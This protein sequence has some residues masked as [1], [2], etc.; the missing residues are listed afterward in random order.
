MKVFRI[1]ISAVDYDQLVQS[2]GL[3]KEILKKKHYCFECKKLLSKTAIKRHNAIYHSKPILIS[4]HNPS[5]K[6]D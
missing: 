5:C 1:N 3:D 4:N 6:T 2:L